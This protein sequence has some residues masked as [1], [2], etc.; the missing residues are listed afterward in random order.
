MTNFPNILRDQADRYTDLLLNIR[1]RAKAKAMDN[2]TENITE[3]K[4][5]SIFTKFGSWLTSGQN[6]LYVIAGVV[7]V[8][9]LFFKR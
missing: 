9:F 3:S 1:D 4:V 5:N 6:Y 8:G 2:A 7:V